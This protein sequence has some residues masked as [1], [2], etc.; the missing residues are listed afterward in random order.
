MKRLL[1]QSWWMLALR[2]LAAVVFGVIALAWPGITLLFLVAL[3]A[4]YAIV[5][6][7]AALAGAWRNRSERGWWLALLLGI[8]S[9]A[10][11]VI[12]IFYPAI[13]ALVL[14]LVIG[15]NAIFSG[16][17]D[18]SMAIRLRK[19][20]QGEWLLGLAGVLSILFGAFVAFFPGAGALALLW[21][22]AVYAIAIGILLIILAFRVR[23]SGHDQEGIGSMEGRYQG[24]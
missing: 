9:V 16:V 23:R 1:A 21:L 22:I 11:G 10:A 4:A 2:G 14:A 19:E 12:A 6:G 20:I 5:S 8:V 17:L 24:R 3:F 15:I 7:I 13:T 18:V